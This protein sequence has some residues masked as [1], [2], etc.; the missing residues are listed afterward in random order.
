MSAPDPL[1]GQWA[2]VHLIEDAVLAE[3]KY[4]EWSSTGGYA[5]GCT[6]CAGKNFRERVEAGHLGCAE[7]MAHVKGAEG[8]RAALVCGGL[9]ATLARV[10]TDPRLG[11][12]KRHLDWWAAQ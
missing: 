4:A 9:R 2:D 8:V 10:V 12:W 1:E 7:E 6:L 5:K 3:V 11:E